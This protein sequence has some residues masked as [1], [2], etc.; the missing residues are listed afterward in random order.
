ML[1]TLLCVIS[2]ATL[3]SCKK[4]N[5]DLIIGK[6]KC[7]SAAMLSLGPEGEM[8]ENEKEIGKVWEFKS[9]GTLYK[10]GEMMGTYIV[11]GSTLTITADGM[12]IPCQISNLTRNELDFSIT[13]ITII[14]YK[15]T[16]I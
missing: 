12:S 14:N 9:N 11:N 7:T 2:L 3:S 4:D 15:F 10:E 8:E 6:W 5:E 16:K 13:I 1:A